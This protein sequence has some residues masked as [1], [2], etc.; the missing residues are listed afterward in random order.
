MALGT[1]FGLYFVEIKG[2]EMQ[3]ISEG[4]FKGQ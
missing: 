4:Y 3:I 2:T 1:E